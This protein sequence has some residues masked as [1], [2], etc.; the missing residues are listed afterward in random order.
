MPSALILT[1]GGPGAP[2]L[3]EDLAAAGVQV[4]GVADCS[5][6]VRC[7]I[8]NEP[9][10]VMVYDARPGPALFDSIARVAASAP[11]PIVLFTPDPDAESITLATEAGVHAY[12]VNG[13]NPARLR[14][15]MHLAQARFRRDQVLQDELAELN[16][17]FAERRSW[18]A[19]RAS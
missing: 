4:V 14:P 15:V 7:V 12:V 8:K 11:R 13:Y 19:P 17:R 2:T 1:S 3:P 5:N 16:R 18:T 9:D 6:L 10:V